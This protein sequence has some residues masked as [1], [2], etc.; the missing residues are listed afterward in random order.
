M[1]EETFDKMAKYLKEIRHEMK[2]LKK[3]MAH[4][5]KPFYTNQEAMEIFGVCSPT[6]KR[7]RDSGLL[8]YSQ[9][10]NTYFYSKED[11][12]NF[13]ASIHYKAFAAQQHLKL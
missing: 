1:K 2:E 3:G 8:G 13:L 9:F 5:A 4:A 6:L 7:W 10:D 11:I 12:E